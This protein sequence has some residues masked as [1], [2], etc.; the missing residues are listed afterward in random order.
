MEPSS[1]IQRAEHRGKDAYE[2]A[3]AAVVALALGALYIFI[4]YGQNP[5]DLQ[6]PRVRFW[7]AYTGIIALAAAAGSIS[8]NR[9]VRVALCSLAV[10]GAAACTAIGLASIGMLY[11]VPLG[12]T[13]AAL[14]T[15]LDEHPNIWDGI[16][17]GAALL[18]MASIM[19][20]GLQSFPLT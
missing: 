16:V 11:L 4:Q 7:I 15:I 13:F 2:A 3:L 14:M 6:Y 1:A 8:F 9:Y 18:A 5:V 12:L 19:V 17:S 10:W 20:V